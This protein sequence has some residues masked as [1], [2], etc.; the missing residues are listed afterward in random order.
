V[1][2]DRARSTLARIEAVQVAVED[3]AENGCDGETTTAPLVLDAVQLRL[4]RLQR[5]AWHQVR[6][7]ERLAAPSEPRRVQ[8]LC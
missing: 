4:H 2:L 3:L 5:W 7:L 6:D 1:T 8:R